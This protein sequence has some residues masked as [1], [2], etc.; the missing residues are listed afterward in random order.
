MAAATFPCWP[1]SVAAATVPCWPLYR[2]MLM[3]SAAG[4][5]FAAWDSGC[6]LLLS[7]L[8]SGHWWVVFDETLQGLLP[9]RFESFFTLH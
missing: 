6:C 4:R 7:S 1:H 3:V 5:L 8:V 2:C 9:R